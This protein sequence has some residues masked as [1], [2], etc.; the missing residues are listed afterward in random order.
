MRVLLKFKEDDLVIIE[1]TSPVGTTRML[2]SRLLTLRPDL[3]DTSHRDTN[4]NSRIHF[5]Y[6]PERILPGNMI[7][8]LRYNNR[9]VGGLT[10][11]CGLLAQEFYRSL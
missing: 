3:Y 6:C 7:A 1:S 4:L 5:A 2:N 8:E 9:T 10:A 11:E